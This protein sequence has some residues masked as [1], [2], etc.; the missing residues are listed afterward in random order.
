M[1]NTQFFI[2]PAGAAVIANA[3]PVEL[4]TTPRHQK[5]D[6]EFIERRMREHCELL[7]QMADDLEHEII[8]EVLMATERERRQ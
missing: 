1:L 6:A 2:T 3:Q 4:E 7:A 5:F 8:D